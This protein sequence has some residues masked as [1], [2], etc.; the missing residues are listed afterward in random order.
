[1]DTKQM[2]AVGLQPSKNN[3]KSIQK[4]A[5][6]PVVDGGPR[7]LAGA[8]KQEN[9]QKIKISRTALMDVEGA[10]KQSI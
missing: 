3:P 2:D 8:M 6:W 5:M 10:D 1:M 9:N 4:I 7:P